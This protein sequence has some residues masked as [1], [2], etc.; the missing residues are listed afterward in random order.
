ME[1]AA[2]PRNGILPRVLAVSGSDFDSRNSFPHYQLGDNMPAK[3]KETQAADEWETMSEPLPEAW[4]WE[5]DGKVLIG[6]YQGSRHIEQEDTNDKS[7]TRLVALHN[8]T[9]DDEGDKRAV[10]GAYQIDAVFIDVSGE[11]RS[12]LVGKLFRI[13]YLGKRD[14][15]GGREVKDF[16]VQSRS[17]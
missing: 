16:R 15:K 7:K 9:V 12:D 3:K 5:E 11:F 13:E 6:V 1:A 14:I 2:V 10:W 4:N 17:L 8:F